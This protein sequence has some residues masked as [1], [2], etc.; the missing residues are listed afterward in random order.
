MQRMTIPTSR[1]A[2]VLASTAED[3]D[4]GADRRIVAEELAENYDLTIDEAT[5]IVEESRPSPPKPSRSE[6]IGRGVMFL[7]TVVANQ[8]L[9]YRYFPDWDLWIIGA[10][11]LALI[12]GPRRTVRIA[13]RLLHGDHLALCVRQPRLVRRVWD[14]LRSATRRHD[15]HPGVLAH[16]R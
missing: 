11:G 10:I 2:A 5:A 9:L 1:R 14:V 7:M 8:G 15:R 3:L 12:I 16:Q 6:W 4:H 13:G